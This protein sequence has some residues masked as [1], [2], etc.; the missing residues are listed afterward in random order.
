MK[1]ITAF[2]MAWGNF[3]SIPCPCKLWDNN[4]RQQQL[5]FFPVIGLLMGI[6]WYGIGRLLIHVMMPIP[7]S[8]AILTAYPYV[9]SG[10]IH[11]DG[12]MDCS[13]GILSRRS[14]EERQRIL[15]DS[16]V[17][18]FAVINVIL[19]FMIQYSAVWCIL[20]KPLFLEGLVM[21]PV[22][23]RIGSA[24]AVMNFRPMEHS[25][26]VESFDINVN[27]RYTIWLGIIGITLIILSAAMGKPVAAFLAICTVI[28]HVLFSMYGKKQLGGMS[29]DVAGYAL[30]AAECG[31]LVMMA[32]LP[33]ICH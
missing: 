31:T 6:T 33:M 26:Y 16:R 9:I 17:G 27:R 12:F 13:D 23:S 32:V 14:L 3:F 22:F 28:L 2:F 10:C 19:L 24:F 20:D 8:A 5:V 4:L 29:G 25:Q 30:T 15:K 1:L 7:L 21:I 11:L 18:A